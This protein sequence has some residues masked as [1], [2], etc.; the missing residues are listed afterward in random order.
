MSPQRRTRRTALVAGAAAVILAGAVAFLVHRSDG[1]GTPAAEAAGTERTAQLW[2]NVAECLRRHGHPTFR[3]PAI[4]SRG[5][6]DFG[7][8]GAQV[9]QAV[10]TLGTTACRAELAALPAAIHQ[11]PPTTAELH[12]MVLFSRCMRTHGLSDWPDPRADGTFPLNQRLMALGKQRYA[13]QMRACGP[14]MG[15]RSKGIAIS[16]SSVPPG[17][18]KATD[19]ADGQ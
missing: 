8:Q 2:H 3:D 4:D 7:S 9:K 6:P 19:K 10:A 5:D 12:Q 18:E 16:P 13:T 15:S 11:R 1:D 14:L 17:G